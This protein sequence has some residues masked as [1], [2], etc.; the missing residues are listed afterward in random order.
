MHEVDV[1]IYRSGQPTT[2]DFAEFEKLGFKEV[3]NLRMFRSDKKKAKN[4]SLILHHKRMMAETICANDL[5]KA[6]RIIKDRTGKLLIHCHH[7]SDRTGAVIAMYRIIFQGW[8]KEKAIDEMIYGG[9][10]FHS[11]YF[12]IPALINRINVKKFRKRLFQE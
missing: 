11:I 6:L 3:L 9:F 5:L 2:N 8:T 1:D 12:N 7:G 4:S 10:G